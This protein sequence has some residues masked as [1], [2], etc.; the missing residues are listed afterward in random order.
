MYCSEISKPAK[1][2]HLVEILKGCAC[3][4]DRVK[5]VRYAHKAISPIMKD[6]QGIL[7]IK[8]LDREL[9]HVSC[10]PFTLGE[11]VNN[12]CYEKGIV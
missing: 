9:R 10:S 11:G 6:Q 7:H 5:S 8:W 4:D 3:F 2:I 1:Y 12:D